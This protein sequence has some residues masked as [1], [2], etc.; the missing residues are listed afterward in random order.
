MVSYDEHFMRIAL[1]EAAFG[2]GHTSP[3]P[4]VGAVIV[5][6]TSTTPSILGKG[7][8]HGAGLPH[9]EIEAIR[10]LPSPELAKGATIYVTLEPCSTHGRTPP[11]VDAIIAAGFARVIIGTL[12]PNPAHAGRA[13]GI[14]QSQGVEVTH[15][16][17]EVECRRLNVAFNHWITSKRP[18]V[19]AK[20]AISLDGRIS[21]APG[22]ARWLTNAESRFDT[23]QIR[24]RVDAI[25]IGSETLRVDNPQLTVRGIPGARQP[26]R[27]ILAGERPLPEDATVFTDEFKD[28]T[29]VFT[30][31]PFPE[32]LRQLGERNITSVMIEGGMHVLGQAFDLQLVNEAFFYVAPL[33][34]GGPKLATG[35]VGAASTP[36]SA[37]VL[38][39]EYKRIGDDLRL[40]GEVTYPG[41]TSPL[42]NK[43]PLLGVAELHPL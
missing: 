25:L 41:A 30:H 8:H 27:I 31:Q 42:E 3:N 2:I 20:A 4:A 11:C 43:E 29:L 18:W 13:I 21:R 33:L 15:G 7:W 22:D 37:R 6:T 16:I 12:D 19:I 39:P 10:S 5:Q 38:N 32:V 35:G 34:L 14:L 28:K 24:A 9:A 23:H 17:L 26:W 1:Q 36:L 40:S